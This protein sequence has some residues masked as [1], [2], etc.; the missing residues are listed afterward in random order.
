MRGLAAGLEPSVPRLPDL[1]SSEVRLLYLLVPLTPDSFSCGSAALCISASELSEEH[2][3]DIRSLNRIT[4]IN[5]N[6]R[7]K[8][9]ILGFRIEDIE[10]KRRAG[11]SQ[12]RF[13][14]PQQHYPT[15]EIFIGS[16]PQSHA[17]SNVSTLT[18]RATFSSRP[19]GSFRREEE[20]FR[21]RRSV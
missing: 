1:R 14:I 6:Y 3:Q 18:R 12:S 9:S 17:M 2:L 13:A 4:R 5:T 7:N 16:A 11:T 21:L 10:V 20:D 19:S 8:K 15:R